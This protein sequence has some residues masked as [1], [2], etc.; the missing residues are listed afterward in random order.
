MYF[1]AQKYQKKSKIPNTRGFSFRFRGSYRAVNEAELI[2]DGEG[3][4]VESFPYFG[5]SAHAGKS[6]EWVMQN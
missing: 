2:L 1:A 5:K 4:P 3:T 6:S